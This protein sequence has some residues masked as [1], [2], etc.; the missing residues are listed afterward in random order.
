METSGHR[1]YKHI[2]THFGYE[3]YLNF[4]ALSTRVSL[5]RLRLSSHSFYVERGRWGSNKV[6][7]EERKCRLCDVIEDEYHCLIE[8][9]R[10]VNERKGCLPMFL[11]N[12]PNMYKFVSFLKSDK[13]VDCVKAATVCKNV[14]KEYGKYV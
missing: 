3:A 2:K 13:Y 6:V 1:L 10:F 8:C 14:M 5:T 4:C 9:P 7:F 11:K 12:R